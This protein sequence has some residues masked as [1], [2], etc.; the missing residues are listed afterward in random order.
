M[1]QM[2]SIRLDIPASALSIS[3]DDLLALMQDAFLQAAT[4]HISKGYREAAAALSKATSEAKVNSYDDR[5]G[6]PVFY[7]P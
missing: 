3:N 2:K 6:G 1:A 5:Y 7:V 4:S